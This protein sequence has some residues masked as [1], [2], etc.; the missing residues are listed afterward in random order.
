MANKYCIV[1]YC[2]VL[3]CKLKTCTRN[4]DQTSL[5]TNESEKLNSFIARFE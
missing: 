2:I 3:Y 5:K 4:W 1:L